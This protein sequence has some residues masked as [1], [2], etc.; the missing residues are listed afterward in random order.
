MAFTTEGCNK[1]PASCDIFS[2][3]VFHPKVASKTGS[4]KKHPAAPK[5]WENKESKCRR[6]G[7]FENPKMPTVARDAR[8]LSSGRRDEKNSG[9]MGYR[10]YE[11][12]SKRDPHLID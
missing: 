8:V 11:L 4:A 6:N 12:K 9:F 7:S 1:L 3:A 5:P 2:S 10:G